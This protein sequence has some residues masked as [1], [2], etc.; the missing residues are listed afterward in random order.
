VT[1]NLTA[2]DPA[3][4]SGPAEMRFRNGATGA[5]S[6]WRPFAATASWTLTDGNGTKQVVVQVRDAAGNL[7]PEATDTINYFRR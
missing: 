3:P 4:G 1:L 7:S 2:S 6:D 5:W